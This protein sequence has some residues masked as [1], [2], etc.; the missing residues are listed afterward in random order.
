MNISLLVGL[1]LSEFLNV[2][3]FYIYN[4][5]NAYKPR[6]SNNISEKCC[7]KNHI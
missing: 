3:E 4:I 1:V 6:P 5:E 7:N 2:V